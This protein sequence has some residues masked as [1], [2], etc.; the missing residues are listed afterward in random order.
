MAP[1]GRRPGAGRPKGVPN[2]RHKVV[3]DE[4]M[5]A[6]LLPIDWMLAVLRDPEAEQNRR[7]RM[8]EMAAPYLHVRLSATSVTSTNGNAG[9]G[10]DTYITQILAV[11]RGAIIDSTG[12][13]TI[14]G[15]ATELATIEPYA[16]T[17]W[18]EP[19]APVEQPEPAP[20]PLPVI[21]LEAMENPSLVR[22]DRWRAKRDDE[23][24]A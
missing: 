13:V 23:P 17:S 19:F 12:A 24:A 8:A 20:E 11:P 18:G 4:T 2:K 9:G 22:L 6:G 10:G 7:D 14:D 1:G 3:V 5:L 15:A 21:E 16:P